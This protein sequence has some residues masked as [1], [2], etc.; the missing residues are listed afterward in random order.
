MPFAREQAQNLVVT[1]GGGLCL[2]VALTVTA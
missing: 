1:R 2:G